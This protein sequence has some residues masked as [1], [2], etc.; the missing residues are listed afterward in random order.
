MRRP[1]TRIARSRSARRSPSAPDRGFW[2][3]RTARWPARAPATARA[4]ARNGRAR[5]SSRAPSGSGAVAVLPMPLFLQ[6]VGDFPR[7]VGLIVL[8]EDGVGP[9]P[10]THDET[11]LPREI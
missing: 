6:R 11:Y 3:P 1:R 9:E 8:G 5:R 10:A 4:P 2:R 7:H